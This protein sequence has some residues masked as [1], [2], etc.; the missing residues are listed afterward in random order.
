MSTVAGET[1]LGGADVPVGRS[2]SGQANATYRAVRAVE[3]GRL[4]LTELETPEPSPGQVRIRVEACG[5]CHSDTATVEGLFPISFPRS[6]GH[7]VIGRIDA[8]GEGVTGWMAGQRVGVG[9]LGGHCGVCARCRRGDFVGCVNQEVTGVQHDGGYAEVMLARASGLVSVP[10]EL[11]SV[12]AAPLLCA[13]LTTFNALRDSSA[14]SGDLV[15]I[16]GIG[17]LG[18]L[19][20]QYARKMGFRTVAIAR[21]AEK[22]QLAKELGA[23]IYLDSTTQ[24]V[25]AEL[26]ALGGAQVILATASSAPAMSSAFTGLIPGGQMIS[27]GYDTEPVEVGLADLLFAE[28]S[29]VGSL[30]G[31]SADNEDT[32]AFSV[33]QDVRAKIE[34]VSLQ[35]APAGYARMLANQ[36]RFRV[37]ID[38]SI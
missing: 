29:L 34:V 13:G 35:D 18:H 12:E 17:G 15:A 20:V 30:T 31:S 4:E 5:I 24:D 6:P 9:Y 38:M 27:V 36:A 22:A 8:V 37:V 32:L 1:E 21:G 11:S 16:L 7:E 25:A 26:A 2:N 23:H 14:R 3:P 19:G 10:D 33:L 28:R